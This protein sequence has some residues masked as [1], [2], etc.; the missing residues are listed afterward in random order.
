MRR[1]SFQ[2]DEI[3]SLLY[4]L[5]GSSVKFR[6]TW[7]WIAAL[8]VWGS[9][10]LITLLVTGDQLLT[11]IQRIAIIFMSSIKYVPLIWVIYSTA[12]SKAA[13]YL[14]DIYELED[15]TIAG[16]FIEEVAFGNGYEKGPPKNEGKI[17]I[18]EG[19]I[20]EK[21]EHSPIILIGGPGKIKVNLGSAALLEQVDGDPEVIYARKEAWNLESFERIREIGEDDRVGKHQYAA[22]NLRDQFVGGLSVK[23][24][25]K[26]GIPIEAQDIKIIFS[27]LRKPQ[28]IN[29]QDEDPY[30]FDERAV[31]SLVYN[32]TLITPLPPNVSGVAFPWDTTVIPLVTNELEKLI[33]S[34]ALS[35]ILSSISQKEVDSVSDNEATNTQLRV[36]ITGGYTRASQSNR[37]NLRNFESRSKITDLFFEKAFQKKAAELGVAIH[38]IDIGTW[39]LPNTMITEIEG[40]RK[41]VELDK[42]LEVINTA[43]ITN[44][45]KQPYSSKNHDRD[46]DYDE[47][48]RLLEKATEMNNKDKGETSH[49]LRQQENRLP[50]AKEAFGIA[51]EILRAFRKEFLSAKEL[52]QKEN[53]SP[54]E[55]QEEI[56]KIEKALRELDTHLHTHKKS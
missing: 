42:L 18:N 6:N 17:T 50:S 48:A 4:G 38:W 33:T 15:Q 5:K 21:D 13:V 20:S 10:S 35:Q 16:K 40:S 30:S 51:R 12:K 43:I 8:F 41:K 19:K 53:K 46:Y 25:T 31:H 11:P 14:N 32:Q 47:F 44:F 7:K 24:R 27:I 29:T 52:I 3:I 9:L 45:H 1:Q 54:L 49:R 34:S 26:D 2:R 39:Q 22:I 56:S 23:S 36:E 37:M 55:K 28:N